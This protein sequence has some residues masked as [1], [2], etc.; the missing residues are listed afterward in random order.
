[1]H[2]GTIKSLPGGRNRILFGGTRNEIKLSR[3]W[4]PALETFVKPEKCPYCNKPQE[5]L[6]L[7]ER[8][9]TGWRLLPNPATPHDKDHSLIIPSTCWSVDVLQRWGG[10]R[11]IEEALWIAFTM[12]TES[13]GD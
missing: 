5:E 1:M 7:P 11:Y 8:S 3:P 13:S 6:K 10:A 2:L 9:A 12:I 4:Q